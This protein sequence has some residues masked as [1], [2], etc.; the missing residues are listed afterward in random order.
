MIKRFSIFTILWTAYQTDELE[1]CISSQSYLASRLKHFNEIPTDEISTLQQRI[2]FVT[3][4]VY[5]VKTTTT[6]APTITTPR[7]FKN[8]GNSNVISQLTQVDLDVKE[9]IQK[10]E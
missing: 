5:Q 2:E 8:L 10:L 9:S 6:T 3:P 7:R 4:K 1:N